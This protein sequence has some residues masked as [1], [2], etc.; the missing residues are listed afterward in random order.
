MP[1]AIIDQSQEVFNYGFVFNGAFP[2]W[3]EFIFKDGTKIQLAGSKNYAKIVSSDSKVQFTT[4]N[5]E[6]VRIDNDEIP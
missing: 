2:N 6:T 4:T 3:Q 1:P 5:K